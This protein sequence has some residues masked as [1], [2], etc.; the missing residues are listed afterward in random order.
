LRQR[1]FEIEKLERSYRQAVNEHKLNSHVNAAIQQRNTTIRK[2]V[3]TYNNLCADLSALIRQR[4]SPLNAIPP[5]PISPTSIFDLDI[6]ADI[7]EDIGLD[8]VMP[9][10]PDWLADEV[11]RAVIRLLLEI[12]QYNEEESHVKVECCALQVWAMHEWD[13]LQRARAHASGFWT[14]LTDIPC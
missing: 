14:H 9:E 11:T 2:L 12:D 7:W 13:G 3:S 4:H 6:D 5:N 8:D 1:K 10:P